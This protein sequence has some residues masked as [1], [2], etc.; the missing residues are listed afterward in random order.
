M[1]ILEAEFLD[2]IASELVSCFQPGNCIKEFIPRLYAAVDKSESKLLTCA[3]L[4]VFFC[5]LSSHQE[6]LMRCPDLFETLIL[7]SSG[8]FCFVICF[9]L[10]SGTAGAQMQA[11]FNI[12]ST[13]SPEISCDPT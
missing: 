2:G 11:F 5:I 9:L 3:A 13:R 10:T 1:D 7:R 6:V 8:A 12:N 4:A